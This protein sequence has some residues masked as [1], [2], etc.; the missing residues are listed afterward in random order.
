[1]AARRHPVARALQLGALGAGVLGLVVVTYALGWD[2]MRRAIVG[3]GGWFAVIALIDIAGTLCDAL[4]VHGLVRGQA[5]LPYLRAFVAQISGLAINRLTPG[6]ALG[7]PVKVAILVRDEI[8]TGTAVSAIMMFNVLTTLCAIAGIVAGVPLTLLLVDLPGPAVRLMWI[9]AVLVLVGA[10]VIVLLVRRGVLR[11]LVTALAR[12]RAVSSER[13]KRWQAV[14]APIDERVRAISELRGAG[15]VRGVTGVVGSRLFNWLG[16]VVVL[17]A[18]EIPL[19]PPLV[20]AMLSVGILVS[21]MSNV[22]PLG[23]GLADGTNYALYGLLGAS[24]V[25]GLL[26]TMVNRLRT[27]VLALCGLTVMTIA[28][29]LRRRSG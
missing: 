29:A 3:V 23:M 26:F 24:P 18:A 20:I 11:M 17:H 7:E 25:A 5:P 13:A 2:G 15:L 22:V 1:M 12:V 4:A 27:I 8:P 14:V 28:N 6:N 19:H 21:W 16:T 10:V 9:G